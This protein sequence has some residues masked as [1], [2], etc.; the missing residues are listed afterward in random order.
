MVSRAPI[1][2]PPPHE[3][4]PFPLAREHGAGRQSERR[5]AILGLLGP[6]GLSLFCHCLIVL[7][8]TLVTWAVGGAGPGELN[9]FTARVVAAERPG[10]G[11]KFSRGATAEDSASPAE[12]E[13]IE[14]L[15]SL[16]RKDRSLQMSPIDVGSSGLNTLS[17]TELSRSDIVGTGIPGS[18]GVRDLGG[19]LGDR[20][21]A[22]GAPVG[23]LWGVGQ[24]QQARSV[25]Y[26]LDRSG[27]MSGTFSLLQR[28]LRRAVGSLEPDQ[29]FNVIWF[30]EGAADEWSSRMRKATLQNKRK[31]FEALRMIVPQGQTEPVDAVRRGLEYGPD[32]L[33]LLSDGDFGEQ[34][35]RIIDLIKRKNRHKKTIINTILFVYDT[36]GDG[37]RVLRTIAEENRGTYKHVT[38]QDIRRR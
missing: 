4:R 35:R 33:F 27:S 8:L 29:L 30:N 3:Q 12:Q 17:V 13:Q 5:S 16:L 38:E 7:L 9:E 23:A 34:N 10:D 14:D 1:H 25:V 24:G 19:S 11:L 37:E 20:D 2:R 21:L 28:E 22:G 36:V 15:A 31:A 32:V 6:A 26:V 18:E